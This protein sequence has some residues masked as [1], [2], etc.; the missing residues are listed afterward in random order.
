[1]GTQMEFN[2]TQH[3]VMNLAFQLEQK[4]AIWN[5]INIKIG[6]NLNKNSNKFIGQLTRKEKYWDG[7]PFS[8]WN[9]WDGLIISW[10]HLY[11]ALSTK[12]PGWLQINSNICNPNN[13]SKIIV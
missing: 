6:G 5:K 2:V 10:P 3:E 4:S 13:T 1:M 9:N 12:Y 8:Q 11:R 7:K